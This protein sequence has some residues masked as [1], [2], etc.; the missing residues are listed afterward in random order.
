[1]SEINMT[2]AGLTD[3]VQ[4]VFS[5]QENAISVLEVSAAIDLLT[6]YQS[7]DFLSSR[8]DFFD[9]IHPDDQDVVD[10][11]LTVDSQT[12]SS[13]IH[14]RLRRADGRI[15]CL[16]GC[17]RKQQNAHAQFQLQLELQDAR[18]LKQPLNDQVVFACLT[19][20]MED[21]ED[22]IYFKDRN[23]VYMGAS[24]TLVRLTNP[25]QYWA[26]LVGK[27]DYDIFS[28]RYA[29]DYYRL[30]KQLYSEQVKVAHEIQRISDNQGNQRWVD[31]RKYPI[32]E[33]SG[34][35][36]GLVGIARDVTTNIEIEQALTQSEK[37]FR[38][39]FERSPDPC[40][41]IEDNR[42]VQ[43]NNAAVSVLRYPDKK[44]LLNHPS[45]LSPE[46]QE[47][48]QLSYSKANQM[49]AIALEKSIHRFDWIHRRFDGSCFPVEVTLARIKVNGKY[50]LYCVWRD[51]TERK[52]A[53][54]KLRE[55]EAL[56]RTIFEQAGVGVAIIDSNSGKFIQVNQRY[57]DIVGYSHTEMTAGMNF[58]QITHPDDLG[59]DLANMEKLLSG[60]LSE[61]SM[62]KRYYHKDSRVVW[63]RL[64]VSATWKAGEPALSHIAVVEDITERKKNEQQLKLS[65]KVFSSAM[66]GILVTDQQGYIVDVNQAFTD[67]T[68]F[69]REQ[70][71][72]KTPRILK[73]DRQAPEFYQNMWQRLIAN[74]QW[75][76]ELWNQ[77]QNGEEYAELLTIS[78]IYDDIGKV[79]HYV[80]LFSD[81]T[82]EKQRQLKLEKIAHFD[83]LTGV[84]NRI[85]LSDRLRQGIAHHQRTGKILAVCYLDLDGFKEINDNLGHEAGDVLLQTIAQRMID[86]VRTEDTVARIGG[87]EFVL[88]LG[89]FDTSYQYEILLHRL[90]K[91]IALPCHIMGEFVRVSASIGVTF[92]PD[93]YSEES[94][95]LRHADQAMYIAKTSGKGCYHIF[96]PTLESQK[97][98]NANLI[99]KIELALNNGQLLMYYQPQVDCRHD[100]VVG[101]EALLRWDHP[102]LGIRVAAEFLPIVE[103]DPLIVEIGE[104]V[105]DQ[106]M[107][108]LQAW[109]EYQ[110]DFT[111]SVNI[112][113]R[114]LMEGDFFFRLGRILQGY[115][116]HLYSKLRIEVTETTVLEDLAEVSKLINQCREAYNIEFALDDFGVGY[117]SLM[118]LKQMAADELKIDKSFIDNI[119]H[120]C[121]DIAIV[122]GIV[123]LADAFH[124]H[125]MAEVVVSVDQLIALLELGCDIIQGYIMAYPMPA[126]EAIEW[127]CNFQARDYGKITGAKK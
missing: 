76:G 118:Q 38:D 47:D 124:Q 18:S 29:D 1:M 77:K 101:M 67:L 20:L 35:I 58:Q 125:V 49:M 34:N 105:I 31:N 92:Y 3:T 7:K 6:G 95:L 14:F 52:E 12:G 111:V 126:D 65:A 42:F 39:L 43:C 127:A 50:A 11:L 104:W 26:E 33:A 55:N 91:T 28:E 16:I 66:E 57:C 53:E 79:S 70:A 84:A 10:Q 23:H 89:E 108:Q 27:T 83:V 112:A 78:A 97:H 15:I 93:D 75:R 73:S 24:Q 37:R 81:V 99:E 4:L 21:S 51:I 96:N 86:T 71:I 40:W 114:Q 68:G 9:L 94:L 120:N 85:L 13:S 116:P 74:G 25:G 98:E 123:S 63:V 61:F 30:E 103:S 59:A 110:Q 8:Q 48:G 106:V 113:A 88:L 32:K 36:I 54:Q 45:E 90:L 64:T 82:K 121:A 102:L 5:I 44:R 80:G 119:E 62:E 22:Y 2:K 107:K 109:S 72:G 60:E 17:Y 87:D 100:K 56:L 115:P 117:S 69:S 122:K 19:S 41:I 46:Y